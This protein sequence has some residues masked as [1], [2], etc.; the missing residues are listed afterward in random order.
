MVT[1]RL[2]SHYLLYFAKQISRNGNYQL[3]GF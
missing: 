2:F 3:A 1:I